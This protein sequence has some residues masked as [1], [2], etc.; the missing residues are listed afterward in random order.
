[1][2]RI[3]FARLGSSLLLLGLVVLTGVYGCSEGDEMVVEPDYLPQT[4][5]DNVLHNFQLAYRERQINEYAKL[6]ASDFQFY[7]D[8]A[9]R[10]QLGIEFWTRTTDSLRTEQL[11]TSPE[12][13]K[14]TIQ[15]GWNPKSASGAGFLAPRDG[16]TKLFLTDVFLDVDFQPAGQEVTTFRVEDQTQRFYFR[17]GRTYPA[18]GP[19]DTLMYIVEWRDQGT[20]ASIS[21]LKAN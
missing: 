21:E 19:A 15:L 17:R 5:E 8:P 12:V 18:S 7:F 20:Q 9:T 14:I 10:Q 1:M 4:T 16:W 6:L 2:R 13:T 11:F 3:D